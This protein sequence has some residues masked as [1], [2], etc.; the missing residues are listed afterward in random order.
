M[1]EILLINEDVL[2]SVG[3]INDNVDGVYVL[4]SIVLAQEV[5]LQELIG[6]KLLKKIK[7][8]VSDGTIRDDANA[9]YKLL[10]EDY[11]KNYL[12]WQATSEIQI[13]VSFKTT[14]SGVVQNQ[15]D[16]KNGVDI[17]DVQYLKEYYADKARFFSR[18]L[19]SYLCHNAS[20]Y[21]EYKGTC[22]DG[23]VADDDNYC[24]IV[25]YK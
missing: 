21:P 16:K 14:N 2:K 11:I 5:G 10:L 15:D 25:F 19:T 20:D 7:K 4:P 24:N 12:I 18:M 6:T 13:P 23:I 1:A 22:K 17:K 8:L 9:K 3:L